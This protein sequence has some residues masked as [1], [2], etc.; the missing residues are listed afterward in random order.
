MLRVC[1]DEFLDF[2]LLSLRKSRSTNNDFDVSE[3]SNHRLE[4]IAKIPFP[5]DWVAEL[6]IMLRICH[7]RLLNSKENYSN[8]LTYLMVSFVL[9]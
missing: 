4:P 2:R 3:N 1:V 5:K 7:R 8:N 9:V 6:P